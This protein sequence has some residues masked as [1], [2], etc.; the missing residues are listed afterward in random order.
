MAK[1]IKTVALVVGAAALIATGVGAVA[2]GSI[3][4]LSVAGISTGTLFLVAG[5]LSVAAGLLQKGPSIPASQTQRLT[6]SVDPRAFRKTVL[7]STAMATDIRYE[8]WSGS[9]QDYCDWIICVASHAIDGIDEIWLNDELAWTL[10]GGPQGKFVGY[11]SVPNIILEGTPGNAFSFASGQWNGAHRLTGCAYLQLRFKVTGNSK[12]A[13]SPFS[14][15]PTTRLTIIGRGAKLYDPRRDS[16]VGGSGPMRADDQSTWRYTTDDGAVIGENLPLQ[17]L[18][19]LLGWRITNPVTGAKKVAVGAGL[20]AKR[21]NLASF[22]IAASLAEELVNRSTGGSEPR[23][24]GAGVISEGDDPKTTLDALCAACCGRF[25]DT[26]GRLSFAVSHNDLAEAVTDEGLLT[27]DVIGAFTWDPDPTM[28]Q[29]P[30]VVRGRYVDPSPNSLYQ[31]IDY[32]EVR[33]D[34]PDGI[35]RILPLDLG[36]VESPSQAQ[37]I[38]K[39]VLQRK[40]YQRAFSASFDIRAW[41]W[42]VGKVVP[43]TF[44]PLGFNRKVF[45]VAEQEV[46]QGGACNMTLREEAQ[47]IYSW[48]ADDRAPVQAA[49]A[50]VYDPT[51]NPLVQAIGDAID[52][53]N[54]RGAYV[55]KSTSDPAT[56]AA[57]YVPSASGDTTITIPAHDVVLEDGRK[58]G[59]DFG[60]FPAATITGLESGKTYGVFWSFTD[61]Q[62]EVELFPA[63]LHTGNTAMISYGFQDTSVS[64]TFT[65]PPTVPS[66]YRGQTGRGTA[67]P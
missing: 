12:K 3:A 40:Q 21:L 47:V 13:E 15:G 56:G 43:F 48:D 5:G 38:A 44:S 60:T 11:F 30:N 65:P 2:F 23:F 7:G 29:T 35:D 33:I 31:L 45:R 19:V 8:E 20:P 17:I 34:S 46:G 41:R 10:A 42:P 24:F 18:R 55:V 50:I 25:L 66:G 63:P 9:N 54:A 4:A 36:V 49:A 1:A 39:Q 22:Q 32:P 27:A 57:I 61:N 67:I 53:V 16:T 62:Y 59:V 26:A 64:G 37:R 51:K 52:G 6:A 58:S 28:E 14:S